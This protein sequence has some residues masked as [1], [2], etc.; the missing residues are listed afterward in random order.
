MVVAS[1]A[2]A[3]VQA[4]PITRLTSCEYHRDVVDLSGSRL[5]ALTDAARV[6]A[7]VDGG[8]AGPLIGSSVGD[9]G[10]CKMSSRP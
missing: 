10:G 9:G 1:R 6:L 3:R 4:G 7:L 5:V 8:A 2:D